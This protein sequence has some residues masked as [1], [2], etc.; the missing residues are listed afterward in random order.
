MKKQDLAPV[1]DHFYVARQPIFHD[2]NKI[3]GYELLFRAGPETRNAEIS[4]QDLATISV[5]S[6]GSSD[7]RS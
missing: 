2:F 7:P 5:A 6:C 4:D 3:W 1:F